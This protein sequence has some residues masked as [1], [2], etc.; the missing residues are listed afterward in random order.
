MKKISYLIACIS[1]F[2]L[3]IQAQWSAQNSN[4]SEHLY[5]VHF[6]SATTGYVVGNNGTILKTTNG[7]LNWTVQTSFTSQKLNSVYFTDANTGYAVGA[8]G[9]IFKTTDAGVNWTAQTSG[10]TDE[11]LTVK[12]LP[13]NP[14]VIFISGSSTVLKTSDAGQNWAAIDGNMTNSYNWRA[15]HPQNMNG[16]LVAGNFQ[17]YATTS[18]SGSSWAESQLGTVQ[19]KICC[20]F[21]AFSFPTATDGYLVSNSGDLMST[22][23]GGAN[24]TILDSTIVSSYSADA[25]DIHFATVGK[26]W[27]FGDKILYTADGGTSWAEQTIP[28]AD[29]VRRAFFINESLGYAVGSNGSI[30]K[31]TN[32]GNL[33]VDVLE[34]DQVQVNIFP[35]PAS[36]E[37]QVQLNTPLS[38]NIQS[39]KIY[40]MNG[41]EILDVLKDT[42]LSYS[43]KTNSTYT[44]D[45]HALQNG[46][47]YLNLVTANGVITEKITVVH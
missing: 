30:I 13:S 7:G 26:G 43:N 27:I 41:A 28:T 16:A 38:V 11:L 12:A 46:I 23:D 33:G 9:V 40:A 3:Q 2:S 36:K 6:T 39:V 45:A 4:T 32:G 15:L 1:F 20:A 10:V 42:E 22:V 37:F 24:W 29:N 44:I 17:S 21:V 25:E 19:G 18:N 8:A 14:D 34:Q 31:T 47:Y 35:M 5:G